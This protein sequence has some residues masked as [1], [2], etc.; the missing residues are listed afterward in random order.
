VP[1]TFLVIVGTIVVY[2]GFAPWLTRRLKL[3][4]GQPQGVLIVGAHDW[5]RDIAKALQ[6]QKFTVLL[7]DSNRENVRAASLA[8]LTARYA[9]VLAEDAFEDAELADVGRLLALTPNDEVNALAAQ[10]FRGGFGQAA[11]YQL[12]PK[13]GLAADERK[14]REAIPRHLRGRVLFAQGATYDRLQQWVEDGRVVKV[15]TL[16]ET[17]SYQAFLDLYGGDALPL[18]IVTPARELVIVTAEKAPAGTSGQTVIALV[19][20]AKAE[21]QRPAAT[22]AAKSAR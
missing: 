1:L 18:F 6:A 20:P 17:F 15:T 10:R 3:A 14:G 11:V 22:A 12:A 2:G 8:G 5:A 4:R 7:V 21:G 16:S 19:D 13:V 9:N